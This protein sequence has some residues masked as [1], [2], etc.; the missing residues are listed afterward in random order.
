[1]IP[2]NWYTLLELWHGSAV[3]DNIAI[4]LKNIFSY[5][6]ECPSIDATL[7]VI[8]AETFEEILV[9]VP[10]LLQWTMIVHNMMECYNTLGTPSEP[11]DN[12]P[13]DIQ[14]PEP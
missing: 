1:M 7:Q 14:I 12:D 10:S 11:E 9:A 8:K 3:W 13:H 6:D 5:A 4:I 2:R